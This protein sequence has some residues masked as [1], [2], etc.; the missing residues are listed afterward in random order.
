MP[1]PS[2]P[3]TIEHLHER[4]VLDPDSAHL[5]TWRHRHIPSGVKGTARQRMERFNSDRA[6]KPALV[7]IV[8][9]RRRGSVNYVN[10]WRDE[11]V[12]AMAHGAWPVG[13]IAHLNGDKL[14]DHPDNLADTGRDEQPRRAPV[15]E[16]TQPSADSARLDAMEAA[17]TAMSSN[18]TKLV[19]A[20]AKLAN[21][22]EDEPEMPANACAPGEREWSGEWKEVDTPSGPQLMY[23]PANGGIPY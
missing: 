9:G 8:G 17:I 7:G 22:K 16:P 21:V 4:L 14:D 11:V 10:C 13:K 5:L 3:L 19:E 20:V 15:P 2:S 12:Y 18:I 6:G 23:F 1:K